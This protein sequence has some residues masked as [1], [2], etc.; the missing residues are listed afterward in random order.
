MAL[1]TYYSVLLNLYARHRERERRT[2]TID[3]L[4]VYTCLLPLHKRAHCARSVP[5]PLA[6]LYFNTRLSTS[7]GSQLVNCRLLGPLRLL[8][9]YMETPAENPEKKKNENKNSNSTCSSSPGKSSKAKPN[10]RRE[11]TRQK[12]LRVSDNV[13]L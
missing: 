13:R 11:K 5:S 8:G 1:D 7:L 3:G 2:K 4:E 6:L 12:R 9:K 10:N